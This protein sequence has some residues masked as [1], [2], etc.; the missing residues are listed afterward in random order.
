M[1]HMVSCMDLST[2]PGTATVVME[3]LLCLPPLS[4]VIRGRAVA[5]VHRF[6]VWDRLTNFEL[7]GRIRSTE[8][9][10]PVLL[11]PSVIVQCNLCLL[12]SLSSVEI[13]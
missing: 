10:F 3:A 4:S 2:F 6:K 13:K 11:M 9:L 12:N 5:V 1:Q 8:E 7:D